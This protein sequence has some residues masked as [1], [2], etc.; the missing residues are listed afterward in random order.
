MH[1]KWMQRALDL[2]Q[3]GRFTARPNP[4]VGCVIVK[5]D[6]LIAEGY[7][8]QAGQPHAEV[9]ALREAGDRAFGATLYVTLEP[10]AHE[11]R[12]APCVDA[13]IRAQIK[14]VIAAM[15]DPFSE[16]AGKGFE[17]LKQAGIEVVVGVLE[18]KARALNPGFLSW[19]ERKRPYV[20]AKM[21][22][23][24]DGR[25]ALNNGKS[26]WISG[27]DSRAEVQYWRA[28]SGVVLTTA[29]TILS[30]N[31]SLL[32][33]EVSFLSILNFK[34]PIRAIVDR[35]GRTLGNPTLQYGLDGASTWVFVGEGVEIP[36]TLASH[37]QCIPFKELSDIFDYFAKQSIQEVLVEAGGV[38]L[39]QLLEQQYVDEMVLFMAPKLLGQDAKALAVLPTLSELSEHI[40]LR[41]IDQRLVGSDLWLRA[42]LGENTYV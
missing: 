6:T 8:H 21:A 24:L 37:I 1:E 40:P 27:A 33:R 19:V 12:T 22:T 11:G 35:Q 9:I 42:S 5:D 23:S 10:C 38:F 4:C 17:R 28:R 31:P 41:F 13:L 36:N 26:Q 14:T 16:V 39:G 7:H 30:D 25:I 2:A 32:V 20:R 15:I 3:K 34:Q 18:Q 29:E